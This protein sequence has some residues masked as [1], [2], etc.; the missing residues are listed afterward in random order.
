MRSQRGWFDVIELWVVPENEWW[1]DTP[2]DLKF[3]IEDEAAA[4]MA[5]K[6]LPGGIVSINTQDKAN[7]ARI[8]ARGTTSE[9]R[10]L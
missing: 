8:K 5:A 3:M 7:A 9:D 4:R 6:M 10:E 2:E 1:Y